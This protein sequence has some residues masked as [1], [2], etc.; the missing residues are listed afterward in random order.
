MIGQITIS[1]LLIL[2]ALWNG[3]VIIWCQA[4][5]K[6]I[7]T[8]EVK[9]AV[10]YRKY[11]R[12]WHSI[13]LIWRA[14]LGVYFLIYACWGLYIELFDQFSWHVLFIILANYL[15]F[16][17]LSYT[18]YDILINLCMRAFNP[19]VSIW[20]IDNK[21]FNGWMLKR[22]GFN[23]TWIFRGVLI[24]INSLIIIL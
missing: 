14:V 9:Y 13:G 1:V 4:K 7:K 19:E 10:L 8:N 16:L 12:Q 6:F 21:G 3:K 2:L 22:L 24:L 18:V 11:S 20:H 15:W 5:V 17:N 23:G